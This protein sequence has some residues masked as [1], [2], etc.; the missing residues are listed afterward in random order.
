MGDIDFL[1]FQ[2][3]EIRR[4]FHENCDEENP[5]YIITLKRYYIRI[6][7]IKYDPFSS[8]KIHEVFILCL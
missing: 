5:I 3:F 1:T 6:Q 7:I 2:I 8:Q 4:H